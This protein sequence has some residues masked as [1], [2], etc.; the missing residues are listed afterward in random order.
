VIG[1]PAHRLHLGLQGFGIGW[2]E[3]FMSLIGCTS[4]PDRRRAQCP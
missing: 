1:R 3:Q 4:P 2:V